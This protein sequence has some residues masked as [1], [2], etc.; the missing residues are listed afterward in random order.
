V[1]WRIV[2]IKLVNQVCMPLQ[3]PTLTDRPFTREFTGVKAG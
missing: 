2:G 3:D 1:I